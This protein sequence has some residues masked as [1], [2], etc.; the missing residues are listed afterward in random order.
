MKKPFIEIWAS[1]ISL[2]Q[3]RKVMFFINFDHPFE[4]ELQRRLGITKH[5]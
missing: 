3:T 1:H 5:G 2:N 4:S